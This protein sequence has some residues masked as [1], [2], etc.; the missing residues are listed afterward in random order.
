MIYVPAAEHS[1]L[2]LYVGKGIIRQRVV[3][4]HRRPNSCFRR[5]IHGM[6]LDQRL[7]RVAC[8]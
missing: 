1:A 3:G 7:F 8:A 6:D 4:I 5:A 2:V